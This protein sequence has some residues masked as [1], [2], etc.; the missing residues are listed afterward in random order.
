MSFAGYFTSECLKIL[1]V[2]GLRRHN[3]SA[4]RWPLPAKTTEHPI[5]SIDYLFEP[6][7]IAIT[8]GIGLVHCDRKKPSLRPGYRVVNVIA[9][10]PTVG[11]SEGGI[12]VVPLTGCPSQRR[13][14]ECNRLRGIRKVLRLKAVEILS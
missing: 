12:G 9:E 14:V 11:G 8:K 7:V 3:E 13:G 1:A 10:A 5:E 2:A 6:T 4:L